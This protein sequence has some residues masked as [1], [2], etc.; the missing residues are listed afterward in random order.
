MAGELLR[1][2]ARGWWVLLVWGVV[3]VLFGVAAFLWPLATVVALALAIG[4][5][6]IA[7]GIAALVALFGS[8]PPMSRGWLLLY[9][10]VS[11]VFG[12][13]GVLNPLALA[14][15]LLLVFAIWLLVAGV[16]RIV[17]AI[18]VRKEIRGEWLIA[19]SGALA[20]LLGLMFLAA[21]GVGV[22]TMALWIGAL[23]FVYGCVQ[24]MAGIRL[25][26]ELR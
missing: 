19:L 1:K 18:R 6:A 23:A 20:I 21:P 8:E 4:I 3:S 24:I 2:L 5:A 14:G 17:F 11:V 12:L 16:M 25:R 22:L 15:A 10:V 9:A 7:E 13:M 26:R